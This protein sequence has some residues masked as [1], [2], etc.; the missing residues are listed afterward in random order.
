[1][2]RQLAGIQLE[3][4]CINVTGSIAIKGFVPEG[5]YEGSL[6]RSAWKRGIST[7]PSRRVWGDRAIVAAIQTRK[8]FSNRRDGHHTVPTGRTPFLP[9]SRHFVPG[10]LHKVPPGQNRSS[11]HHPRR[12]QLVRR[13]LR[14]MLKVGLASEA[15]STKACAKAEGRERNP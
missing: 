1:V 9:Y 3:H 8:T 12:R 7:V 15:R 10:Y 4:M 11:P 2:K 14:S 5:P 13:S 6:A